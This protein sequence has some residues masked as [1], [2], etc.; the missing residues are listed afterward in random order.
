MSSYVHCKCP[1]SIVNVLNQPIW[2]WLLSFFCSPCVIYWVLFPYQPLFGQFPVSSDLK[3]ALL[4]NDSITCFI[5]W[6]I[7]WCLANLWQ[8]LLSHY[9]RDCFYYYRGLQKKGLFVVVRTMTKW[10]LD[11]VATPHYYYFLRQPLLRTV[12]GSLVA[13]TSVAARNVRWL[14]IFSHVR[15]EVGLTENRVRVVTAKVA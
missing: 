8:H 10:T 7:I 14:E 2:A 15:P 3:V 9:Y 13:L 6:P 1:L 11:H 12:G 5:V 4:G